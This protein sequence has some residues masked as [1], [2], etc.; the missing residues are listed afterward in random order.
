M[1]L[2]LSKDSNEYEYI[3]HDGLLTLA[4]ECKQCFSQHCRMWER[5]VQ[6]LTS[7]PSIWHKDSLIRY[8]NDINHMLCTP[9]A[10]DNKPYQSNVYHQ[11][12]QLRLI[13]KIVENLKRQKLTNAQN[14]II[15]T[16]IK[17]LIRFADVFLSSQSQNL[18]NNVY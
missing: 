2:S 15:H 11:N 9:Q 13:V 17:L 12:S 14:Q 6:G 1:Q 3:R 5:I 18:P 10:P 8:E 7:P 16:H 4:S